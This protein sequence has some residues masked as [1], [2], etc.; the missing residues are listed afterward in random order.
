MKICIAQTDSFNGDIGLGLKTHIQL[1]KEAIDQKADVIFFPELSLTGYHTKKVEEFAIDH[2]DDFWEP[3]QTCSDSANITI[4]VGAPI[5]TD[6]GIEISMIIFQ[7]NK[8]RSTYSKQILHQDELAYFSQG[9]NQ[10]YVSVCGSKFGLGICYESLQKDHFL[11][12]YENDIDFYLS[13][14]AK[15]KS[16]VEKAYEYFSKMSKNFK[17][18]ILMANS[19]GECSDFINYGNSAIWND[20]GELCGQLNETQQGLLIYD[21]MLKRSQIVYL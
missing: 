8:P 19:V 4:G 13:S 3:L 21:T 9:L 1:I 15:P 2:L 16:G 14:S 6:N 20:K 7:S 5:Q 11:E 12:V 17:T 10:I 18:P